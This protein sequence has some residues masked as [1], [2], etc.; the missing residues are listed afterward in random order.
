MLLLHAGSQIGITLK[1]LEVDLI[2]TP[3]LSL[4]LL[5]DQSGIYNICHCCCLIKG[6]QVPCCHATRKS[7]VTE[8]WCFRNKALHWQTAD[9]Q[10]SCK[11]HSSVSAVSASSIFFC[12][13]PDGPQLF[14][15]YQRVLLSWPYWRALLR[16]QRSASACDFHLLLRQLWA[17][18]KTEMVLVQAL[19]AIP[20]SNIL[21]S[22]PLCSLKHTTTLGD[23]TKREKNPVTG[24]GQ[25]QIQRNLRWLSSHNLFIKQA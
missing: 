23:I 16:L 12:T 13:N 21:K 2:W 20:T 14:T 18:D 19:K 10:C 6:H 22:N 15:G 7:T 3:A 11:F 8:P 1:K 17:I 25:I 9:E 24:F 4:C 5:K